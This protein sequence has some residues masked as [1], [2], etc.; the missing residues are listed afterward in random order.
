[1]VG[2]T[3]NMNGGKGECIEAVGEKARKE[4]PLGRPTWM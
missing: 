1:V 3:C 4:G 2:G